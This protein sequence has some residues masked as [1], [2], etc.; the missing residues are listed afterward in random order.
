MGTAMMTVQMQLVFS[1]VS[2]PCFFFSTSWTFS[3]EECAR[4]GVVQTC[5]HRHTGFEEDESMS[6]LF[7]ILACFS[8]REGVVTEM[9]EKDD[10]TLTVHFPA[11]GERSVVRVWHLLP[12]LIWKDGEWSEWSTS[13]GRDASTQGDVP[14]EKRL[15]L[16]QPATEGREKGN[17]SEN[18]EL[19][20][21]GKP[22]ESQLLPLSANEIFFNAGKSTW[23]ENKP[24]APRTVRSGL[25]EDGLKVIFG[26]PKPGKKRKFMEASKHCVAEKSM[27]TNEPNDSIK[28]VNYLMPQRAGSRGWRN[29]KIDAKQ[30]V[31]S[32]SKVL[33]SGKLQSVSGRTLSQEDK[34][35]TSALSAKN[36]VSGKDHVI[37]D[38]VSTD[39]N[40]SGQQNLMKS[41]S[42]FN[43]ERAAEGPFLFS[44]LALPLDSHSKKISTSKAKSVSM[45]KG[46]PAPPTGKLSKVEVDN[47]LKSG[48]PGKSIPDVVE[49]W[50]SNRR[51]QPTSRVSF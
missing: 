20:E 33:K 18:T 49:Q 34:F 50:R 19:M 40:E 29:T 36:E 28:L 2:V 14:R 10:T 17:I 35:L 13:R 37:K 46:K 42:F 15:K 38:S 1:S 21:S 27:K 47:K 24:G 9:N 8:W 43:T 39:K 30:P 32:K 22:K 45:N 23:D 25:Q 41:G 16:G 51:I 12:T 4:S 5:V 11:E 3:S 7:I 48:N 26:V 44:S 6:N 31:E